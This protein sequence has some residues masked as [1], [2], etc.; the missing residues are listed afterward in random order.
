ME[1]SKLDFLTAPR[2]WVMIIGAFAIYFQMKGL[3]GEA[4]MWLIGTISAGFVGVS[5]IDKFGEK[6][7]EAAI[8]AN[9]G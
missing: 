7:V 1:H 2:F 4:E 3:I 8:V 9:E 6:K 5:T